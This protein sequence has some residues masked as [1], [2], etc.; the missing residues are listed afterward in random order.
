MQPF[1]VLKIASHGHRH[2]VLVHV[3]VGVVEEVLVVVV[4][5][6]L[7]NNMPLDSEDLYVLKLGS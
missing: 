4:L 5:V 1:I 7:N 6:V 2:H 3:G